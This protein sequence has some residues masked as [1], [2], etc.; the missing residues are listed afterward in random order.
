MLISSSPQGDPAPGALED[1]TGNPTIGRG[2]I[3]L[4]K[5]EIF[6]LTFKYLEFDLE[7]SFTA[8]VKLC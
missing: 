4:L 6:L 2:G 3:I 7:S 1:N 5:G 8:Y